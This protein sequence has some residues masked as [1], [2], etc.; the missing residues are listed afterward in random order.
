MER[1]MRIE[2]TPSV[3]RTEIL[4]LNYA[5]IHVTIIHHFAGFVKYFLKKFLFD[6]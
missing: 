5:R 2:L 3:W 6:V 1:M 4:P